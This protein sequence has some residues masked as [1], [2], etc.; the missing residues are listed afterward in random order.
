[1]QTDGVG[2]RRSLSMPCPPAMFTKKTSVPPRRVG[3]IFSFK[4]DFAAKRGREMTTRKVGRRQL[5][6]HHKPA[7]QCS[8]ADKTRKLE[9]EV[10]F[11]F[12]VT[13]FLI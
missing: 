8:Q 10:A 6:G 5:L 11:R 3:A 7:A 4:W 13:P 2:K 9:G 12:R 1:M